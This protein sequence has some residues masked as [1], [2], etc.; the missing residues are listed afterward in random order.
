MI[1]KSI[2][3]NKYN[4]AGASAGRTVIKKEEIS[5]IVETEYL[6]KDSLIF[7]TP[8]K[9]VAI[10]SKKVEDNKFEITLDKS[11]DEDLEVSWWVVN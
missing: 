6:T 7:V 9:P 1:T 10:G 3:S 11:L 4:V 2:T 5:V 8:E